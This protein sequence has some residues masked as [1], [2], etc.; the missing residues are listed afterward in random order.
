[1]T[2]S[3][4]PSNEEGAN[5]GST[6]WNTDTEITYKMISDMFKD[7]ILNEKPGLQRFYKSNTRKGLDEYLEAPVKRALNMARTIMD[8]GCTW[9]TA[10]SLSLIA[11]YDLVMLLGMNCLPASCPSGPPISFYRPQFLLQ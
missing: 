5:G 6:E 2:E 3:R 1:M 9:E 11:L 10:L 4:N 8:K 7:Y